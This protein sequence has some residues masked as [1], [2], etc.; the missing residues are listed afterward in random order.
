MVNQIGKSIQMTDTLMTLAPNT[1]GPAQLLPAC[2]LFGS[3]S[4][5]AAGTTSTSIPVAVATSPVG[6]VA[7]AG[8][9]DNSCRFYISQ[10]FSI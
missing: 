9:L 4:A 5:I 10:G 2:E 6:G 1:N 3:A 7:A 8:L